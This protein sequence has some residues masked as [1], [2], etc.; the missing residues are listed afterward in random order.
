MEYLAGTAV[1]GAII[2]WA[3]T[4]LI[5]H[6]FSRQELF[7]RLCILML[8]ITYLGVCLIVLFKKCIL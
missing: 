8:L 5:D 7:S 4:S 3:L 2:F 6:L 1:L